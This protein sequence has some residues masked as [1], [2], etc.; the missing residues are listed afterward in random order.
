[1]SYRGESLYGSSAYGIHIGP[2]PED[3]TFSPWS[4]SFPS[5]RHSGQSGLLFFDGH[6]E[7]LPQKQVSNA[8]L[9]GLNPNQPLF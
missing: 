8:D 4:T 3:Y 5:K 9:Y 6:T 2:G 1:M 7:S